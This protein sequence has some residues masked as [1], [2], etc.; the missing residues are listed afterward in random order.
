MSICRIRFLWTSVLAVALGFGGF[1]GY[2]GGVAGEIRVDDLSAHLDNGAAWIVLGFVSDSEK[3]PLIDGTGHQLRKDYEMALQRHGSTIHTLSMSER[4]RLEQLWSLPF[5]G[6]LTDALIEGL[7]K[8]AGFNVLAGSFPQHDAAELTLLV[9]DGVDHKRYVYYTS[10]GGH[11]ALAQRRP[12]EA[13]SSPM[14]EVDTGSKNVASEVAVTGMLQQKL[15]DKLEPSR[16]R[17]VGRAGRSSVHSR[18]G[19]SENLAKLLQGNEVLV[20]LQKEYAGQSLEIVEKKIEEM[21]DEGKKSWMASQTIEYY[22][23]AYILS[24]L[25][26]NSAEIQEHF[27]NEILD[28]E[29]FL[30]ENDRQQ[31]R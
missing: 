15:F 20:N 31:P 28:R 18:R 25:L 30:S 19:S 13:V 6:A 22:S 10:G 17:P 27:L 29:S 5:E 23:R 12:P 26:E 2:E 1:G 3:N 7:G 24:L 21:L 11:P 14:E 9:H 4:T 8:N 16:Q